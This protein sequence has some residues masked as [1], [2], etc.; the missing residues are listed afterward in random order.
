MMTHKKPTIEKLL[1]ERDA[2]ENKVIENRRAIL[3][4]LAADFVSPKVA[5]YEF[6]ITV[7][8]VHHKLNSGALRAITFEG[9]VY[10][11]KSFI[12]SACIK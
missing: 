1:R 10:V 12:R 7:P 9:R 4:R 11:N 5:A 8:G 2:L 3:Q 6:G